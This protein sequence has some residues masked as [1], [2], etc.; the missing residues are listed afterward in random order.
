MADAILVDGCPD[1]T[2]KAT[3]QQ[4]SPRSA[5]GTAEGHRID[6]KIWSAPIRGRR[7][8]QRSTIPRPSALRMDL[9][10]NLPIS[11]TQWEVLG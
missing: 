6:L 5:H 9:C 8:D 4:S 3:S 11:Q 10:S 7:V 2:L 1:F